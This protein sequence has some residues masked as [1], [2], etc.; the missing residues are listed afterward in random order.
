[1]KFIDINALCQRIGGTRPVHKSTIY[2]MIARGLLPKPLHPSPG[3]ARWAEEEC[4]A[5]L[6]R[7][8]EA[9]NV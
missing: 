7:G 9:R 2:R 8:M 5:A 6:A 1:M 4:E 3:I